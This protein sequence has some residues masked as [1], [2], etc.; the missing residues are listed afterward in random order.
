MGVGA[1]HLALKVGVEGPLVLGEGMTQYP[2]VQDCCRVK[3]KGRRTAWL[4]GAL[5]SVSLCLSGPGSF[6]VS[7]QLWG[8]SE[9]SETLPRCIPTP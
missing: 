2:R 7:G 5:L 1:V 3:S 9:N 6:R 4:W 8:H